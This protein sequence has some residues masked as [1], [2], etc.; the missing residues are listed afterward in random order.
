MQIQQYMA[1]LLVR[2]FIIILI[3]PLHELAHGF[4]ALKLGDP[5]AKNQGRLTL[6]PIKH[7]DPIGSL[8]L[9][10]LGI[11]WAKPVPIN[12][13][14]FKR[15]K[16]GMALSALAGPVANLLAAFV[17][18]I[19]FKL[20]P[21]SASAV[22][23]V[24]LY[25]IQINIFLAVFNLIPVPPLDG[26]RI[27][28]LFLPE[29]YYFNLMKYEQF[30]FIGLIILIFSNVLSGPLSFVSNGF[31]FLFDKLTWFLGSMWFLG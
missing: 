26:S 19:L 16:E 28:L 9:L 12:P 11:G 1:S 10:F 20:I 4:V 14:Y 2:V 7:L 15:R 21:V 17:G 3:L 30:I 31:M 13:Y 6:N 8:S 18:V 22:Q 25:F 5:T 29:K 24:V 23:T 27:M